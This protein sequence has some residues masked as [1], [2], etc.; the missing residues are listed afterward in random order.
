MNRGAICS[1]H[2]NLI[3]FYTFEIKWKFLVSYDLLL[4]L[5][6]LVGGCSAVVVGY[7]FRFSRFCQMA[8]H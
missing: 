3:Y 8:F 1:K 5:K 6:V 4:L 2:T 7:S